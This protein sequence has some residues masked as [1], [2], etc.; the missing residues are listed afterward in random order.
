MKLKIDTILKEK[1]MRMADLA[2]KLKTNQS[3]LSKSL[4][5][6]PKL[7]KL[8]DIADAL[9]VNV[10]DLFPDAPTKLSAGT[11]QMGDK[12]YALV[13]IDTPRE[14]YILSSSQFYAKAE[15]FIVNS[16]RS[17]KT[18]SFCGI[19]QGYCPVSMIFDGETRRLLLSFAPTEEGFYTFTYK[20]EK[21]P[22]F[23]YNKEM[24]LTQAREVIVEFIDY[25]RKS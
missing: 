24:A 2:K 3:N 15:D 8:F 18:G 4:E 11:L 5:G 13:P 7:S 22:E 9:N 12:Q 16:I 17:G 6:N 25:I 1:G 19:Y 14:P 23:Y 21:N 20:I 10:Q